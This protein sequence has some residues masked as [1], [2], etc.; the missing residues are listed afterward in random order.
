M[1]LFFNVNVSLNSANY[2]HI[3]KLWEGY[4]SDHLARHI[5][6]SIGGD[7]SYSTAEQAIRKKSWNPSKQLIAK[8]KSIWED[9]TVS[10]K[11]HLPKE[12]LKLR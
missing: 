7:W 6:E 9:L 11:E 12:R 10:I 5:A 4:Y 3:R 2:E 8:V 1:A